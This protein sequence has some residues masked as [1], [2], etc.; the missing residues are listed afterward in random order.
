MGTGTEGK[1]P[2][3]P[4]TSARLSWP[5]LAVVLTA[6]AAVAIDIF[7]VFVAAP[8]IA[9]D[10]GASSSEI[11]WVVAAYNLAFA[12]FLITG[13]RLGDLWGRKRVLMLGLFV[14][15]LSSAACGAAPDP[16]TLIVARA[17]Q[18]VG[19]AM[20]LPQVFSIIQVEF[21]PEHRGKPLAIVGVVQGIAA[22]GGQLLGGLLIG[23]DLFG[24]EWRTV[25][26]I[27]LPL[28][29][30]GLLFIPRLVPESRSPAAQRLDLGGVGLALLAVSA[31]T[32]PLVQGQSAGWPAWTFVAFALTVPLAFAFVAW[33]RRVRDRGGSPLVELGLFGIPTF[34]VG[35]LLSLV[36]YL[37]NPGVILLLMIYLQEGL[38]LSPVEAGLVYTPA[39]I[40]FA[41]AALLVGRMGIARREHVLIPGIAV[42][43]L[44]V[45]TSA[46]IPTVVDHP[47]AILLSLLFGLIGVGHGIV[48]P[49]LNGTV[50]AETGPAHAGSASGLLITS[51]Q[52]GGALGVALTG[53]I[54]FG[55][56]GDTVGAAA[57]GDALAVAFAAALAA[58]VL[59]TGLAWRLFAIVHRSGALSA[60]AEA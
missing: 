46:L 49:A 52:L 36:F 34:R 13:G 17:V 10:L 50:L 29:A 40:G 1:P 18:G 31:L 8:T 20:M 27:N 42:T 60:A 21:T 2:V 3:A 44:G 33:E 28:C 38:G 11:Q 30:L 22:V 12:L 4:P 19:A 59:A 48:I 51:Q 26:L 45:I 43:A 6:T 55:H 37:A 58:L 16:I 35:V 24:L 54:F 14:F 15:G 53:T 23:L 32:V 5:G 41:A 7:I 47:N 56:L 57:Y 9:A 25:F 39:A